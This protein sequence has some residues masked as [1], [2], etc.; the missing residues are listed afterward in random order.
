MIRV[1]N[2]RN[3]EVSSIYYELRMVFQGFFFQYLTLTAEFA[4]KAQRAGRVDIC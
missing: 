3:F 2:Y 1:L 4:K